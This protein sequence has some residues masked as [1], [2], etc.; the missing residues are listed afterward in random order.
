MSN[1]SQIEIEIKVKI[2]KPESLLSFLRERAKATGSSHQKDEYI[3]PKHRSFLDVRPVTEWLRL[4]E[5]DGKSSIT[6]KNFHYEADGKT[7][8][9]CDEYETEVEN[10]EALRK[11]FLATDFQLLVIVDKER[12][13][14]RYEEYEIAI[15]EVKNL[16][17]FVEIEYK[18]TNANVD[19]TE[20]TSRMID[21]LKEK[22]VGAIDR[23]HFGYPFL[24]LFPGEMK[25]DRM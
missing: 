10:I 15:D 8:N 22:N 3:T 18:G 9:F 12:Q 14:W 1:A 6:Y 2:E 17:S 20:V 16:G 4:R 21:F 25:M 5:T 24:L 7:A 23:V 11:I 13:T 19:P